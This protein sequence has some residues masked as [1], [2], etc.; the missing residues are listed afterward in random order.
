M[1]Y[2]TKSIIRNSNL[3]PLPQ[4]YN[5]TTDAYEVLQGA[6]GGSRVLLY[7]ADGNPLIV[8]NTSGQAS[9][10]KT[11][12][13]TGG[14]LTTLTGRNV[15]LIATLFNALAITDTLTHDSPRIDVSLYENLTLVF[16][17]TLNQSA[18]VQLT[19]LNSQSAAHWSGALGGSIYSATLP[20]GNISRI[21]DK[22]VWGVLG[23]AVNTL[24]IEISC[25]TAPTNGSISVYLYGTKR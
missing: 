15:V 11:D 7:G 6:G 9:K 8:D 13:T 1:G 22:N 4:Y 24:A 12:S 19:G 14:L 2:D 25:N 20:T 3:E 16:E 17:S 5:P 21:A 23:S 18:T 10:L